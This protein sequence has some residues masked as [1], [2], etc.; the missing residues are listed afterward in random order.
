MKIFVNKIFSSSAT[1]HLFFVGVGYKK[2]T[3]NKVVNLGYAF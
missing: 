2:Y 1:S 3:V